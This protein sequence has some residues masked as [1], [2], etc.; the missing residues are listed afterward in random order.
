V[1]AV[2][3]AAAVAGVLLVTWVW[4]QA[5]PP[6]TVRSHGLNA[7][8]VRHAWVEEPRNEQQYAELF[9]HLRSHE[10]SEALFHVGPLEADGTI[11]P[12]RYPRA[13]RLLAALERHHARVA[14][15]D[16]PPGQR[17]PEIRAQAYIGQVEV[18]GGGPLD[19]SDPD[20]RAAIV[21]TAEGFLDLGFDGIH[22]DIEPIEPGDPHFLDLLERTRE[23]TSAR[24]AVL[25]VALEELE[26]VTAQRTIAD[27]PVIGHAPRTT[28]AY[29]GAVAERV[30]QVMIMTYGTY[31]PAD[32]IVG[33]YVAW[34][35]E[36][37]VRVVGDQAAVLMGVPTE[38]VIWSETIGSGIRGVRKAL[39][40][41]DPD[42]RED[43]GVA[44]FAEWTT[45]ADEWAVYR[46][47]WLNPA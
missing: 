36:Q 41:M 11:P 46:E 42:V 7:V 6:E 47:D 13:R 14:E 16:P 44:V 8:W 3:A 43:V 38:D 31:L 18:R 9:A 39:G 17:R 19:L 40:G 28:P 37:T 4:W 35:S 25:S 24:G 1:L 20:V 27:L 15:A 5:D 45:D 30:D 32:W 33:K 29:L 23:V 22:Y 21:T 10:L 26:M 12:E 34:Q 2:T